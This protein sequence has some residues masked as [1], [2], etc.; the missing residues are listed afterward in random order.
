MDQQD[1][2]PA[3]KEDL[4]QAKQELAAKIDNLPLQVIK[5]SEQVS[6]M[7]TKEKFGKA[8]N[9]IIHGQDKMMTILTRIDQERAATTAR[10]DRIES[11]VERIKTR[12]TK[13]KPA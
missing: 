2:E 13:A 8:Y 3:T 6:K 9:E 1:N 5:N 10:I 4:H 7:V 12:Q 11:D